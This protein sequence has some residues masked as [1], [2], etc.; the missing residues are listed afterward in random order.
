MSAPGH[1]VAWL[2]ELWD[3]HCVVFAASR[4]KAQ[5]K[6]VK[7]LREAGYNQCGT[8]P[9]PRAK[10]APAYDRSALS[11]NEENNAWCEEYVRSYPTL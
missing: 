1:I 9:R 5:W 2:V 6:A 8:W 7:A 4:A 3:T 10:R 11:E